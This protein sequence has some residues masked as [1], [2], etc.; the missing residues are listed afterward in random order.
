MN[1]S[2]YTVQETILY[3]GAKIQQVV[4][5][6]ECAELIKEISKALRGKFDKEHMAEEI[7]DVLIVIENLQQIHHI[8]DF[9]IQD[10]IDEKT[11]R[12]KER[13]KNGKREADRV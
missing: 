13:M 5:M 7:A 1:I 2:A 4:A 3:Y 8:P 9:K 10:Y 12:I 6:E 11:E